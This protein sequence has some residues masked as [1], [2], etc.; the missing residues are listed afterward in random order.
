MASTPNFASTPR[1]GVAAVSTANAN[2]DGTGTI[3]TVIT[4]V[5]AGTKIERIVAQATGD[6]ADCTITLFLHDGANFFLWNEIDLGNPAAASTTL[7][8]AHAEILVRDVVLPN[9][10]WSLRAAITAAPTTGV[11]NVFAF[12]ADLT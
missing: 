1:I 12:G 2:R 4:G 5:A 11:V 3:P 6:P 9:A 8:G 7:M 10:S